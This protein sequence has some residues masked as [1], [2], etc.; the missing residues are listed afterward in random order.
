M[1]LGWNGLGGTQLQTLTLATELRSVGVDP[2]VIT[3]RYA[4][5][6][7]HELLQGIPVHRVG[8]F[9][10]DRLRAVSFLFGALVWLLRHRHTFHVIHAHNLPAALTAAL[11]RPLVRAPIIVKL[12]NAIGVEA[13]RGRRMGALRWFIL[14][15]GISRFVALNREIE[16]RLLGVGIDASCI[17]RIPNGVALGNGRPG[18][19]TAEARRSLG[20]APDAPVAIYV[21]RLVPDKG[22]AWLLEAWSDVVRDHPAAQL[23]IAGDGPDG[24]RLRGIV[25]R[26]GLGPRVSFLGHRA[27]VDALLGMADVL[28]LP[29]RSEGMSNALLEGMAHGLAVVASDVPGNREV[30]E[31]ERDGLLVPYDDRDALA[32]AL[33]G[34][35]ADGLR[36]RRLGRE[37]AR[38]AASTFSIGAVATAYH[39]IYRALL[40]ERPAS[41]AGGPA[42]IR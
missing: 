39:D 1:L 33:Q 23:L 17:A 9:P 30:V 22:V 14:R 13:F 16:A 5:L 28:V 8:R 37:A 10:T 40:T 24:E 19:E 20:L 4:G 42:V 29:S 2:V 36:C 27:D 12:P 7:R 18:V 41:P 3:R 32:G 11:L 26:L 31:H 15:R 35:L 21:G 34:L 25:D 6:S 38:K